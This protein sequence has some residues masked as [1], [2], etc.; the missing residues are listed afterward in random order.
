M[1]QSSREE[2]LRWVSGF[3]SLQG[4]SQEA[5]SS[6]NSG[7]PRKNPRISVAGE[8]EKKDGT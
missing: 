5:P 6:L 4:T 3:P 7:G 2:N 1:T 8:M